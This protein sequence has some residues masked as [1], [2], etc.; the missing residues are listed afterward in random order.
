MA[1]SNLFFSIV[2]NSV[3]VCSAFRLAL[4]AQKPALHVVVE[5]PVA[6]HFSDNAFD[7][8]PG[9]TVAVIFTPDDPA[10]AVDVAAFVVRDQ[11]L[12]MEMFKKG[13]LDFYPPTAK[14]WVED[15]ENFDRIKRGVVQR[16]KV[17][18]ENPMGT[19]GLAFN[20][21]KAPFDDVKLREAMAHLL[22]RPGGRGAIGRDVDQFVNRTDP[23]RCV[24]MSSRGEGRSGAGQADPVRG[25]R[26][27]RAMCSR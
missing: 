19:V 25:P 22:N 2:S 18:N 21:R 13:D 8:L 10:T 9:E 17:Y 20:T 6:G 15:L 11:K 1:A 24:R 23:V 7:I 4:T 3:T 16:R 14:N 27:V 12:A 26:G 5:A